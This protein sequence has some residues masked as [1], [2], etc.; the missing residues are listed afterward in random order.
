V[1]LHCQVLLQAPIRMKN[2][3]EAAR[4]I[5]EGRVGDPNVA[6]DGLN[7]VRRKV[8]RDGGIV[9]RFHESNVPSNISTLRFW[10]SSAAYR[11][12]CPSVSVAIANPEYTAPTLDRST[13]IVA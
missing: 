3:D 6:V 1:P 10:P 11:K 9:K 13:A 5:V 7:A 12:V 2:I 4:R 8:L